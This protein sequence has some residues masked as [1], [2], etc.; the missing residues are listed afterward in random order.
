MTITR[1][2]SLAAVAATV[3]EALREAGIDAVLTGGA[4]ATIHSGGAYQSQDLDFVVRTPVERT[5]LD[6]AMRSVGF[7]RDGNRYVHPRTSFF[8]EFPPGPLGIG[9]DLEVTPVAIAIGKGSVLGLSPTDACRDRLAAINRWSRREGH[10]AE[11]EEF[12]QELART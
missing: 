7:E 1:R 8:V 4:C 11:F 5:V 3:G 2:S 6:A 9:D 12:R 10:L